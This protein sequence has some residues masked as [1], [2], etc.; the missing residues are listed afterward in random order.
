MYFDHIILYLILTFHLTNSHWIVPISPSF[1][2]MPF[3]H[4]YSACE[5]KQAVFV[6]LSLTYF[7]YHNE[8]QFKSF[9]R[10]RNHFILLYG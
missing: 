3:F 7:T 2:F 1:M 4:V 5:N 9:S 8:I 6:F 10:P